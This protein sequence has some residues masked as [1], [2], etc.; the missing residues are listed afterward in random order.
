MTWLWHY[1]FVS[2]VANVSLSMH[3]KAH[4][5]RAWAKGLS[6]YHADIRRDMTS[7]VTGEAMFD[8]T[9]R[10]QYSLN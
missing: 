2:V 5:S 9:V 10:G 7:K 8:Y 6:L 4:A 1:P 3:S